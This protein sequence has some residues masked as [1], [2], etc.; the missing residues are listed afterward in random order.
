[1]IRSIL[2]LSIVAALA[3]QLVAGDAFAQERTVVFQNGTNGY[4]GTLDSMFAEIREEIALADVN[5]AGSS[6]ISLGDD[7]NPDNGTAYA[8]IQFRDMIGNGPNR[9][10]PNASLSSAVLEMFAS[11]DGSASD[12]VEIRNSIM[13][14]DLST[15]TYNSLGGAIPLFE[16][17]QLC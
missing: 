3:F 14:F 7:A 5:L 15:A 4:S 10:P 1:M 17:E 16:P 12:L 11:D 8:W 9:I 13:E 6:V 2:N